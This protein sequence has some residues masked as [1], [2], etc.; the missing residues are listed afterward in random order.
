MMQVEMTCD[1]V[2]RSNCGCIGRNRRLK[3]CVASGIQGKRCNGGLKANDNGFK[4][5]LFD[6][7]SGRRRVGV[8]CGVPVE[9]N[10]VPDQL[11]G[12]LVATVAGE[13]DL[14]SP[15]EIMNHVACWSMW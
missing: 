6:A 7:F 5:K 1:A 4:L 3:G 2:V 12:E 14:K 11:E 10:G 13:L 9:D 8:C 15:L